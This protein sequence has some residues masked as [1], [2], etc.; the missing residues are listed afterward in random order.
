MKEA[1]CRVPW[2]DDDDI[3]NTKDKC[4]TKKQTNLRERERERRLHALYRHLVDGRRRAVHRRN[5]HP[6]G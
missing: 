3:R 6:L 2:K 4:L 1:L 5:V